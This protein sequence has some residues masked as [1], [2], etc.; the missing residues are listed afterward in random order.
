MQALAEACEVAT[1]GALEEGKGKN[2]LDP[3]Y[4]KALKLEPTAFGSNLNLVRL[5]HTSPWSLLY[6]LGVLQSTLIYMQAELGILEDIKKLLAPEAGDLTAQLYKLNVYAAPTASV[7]VL[8]QPQLGSD[9]LRE[10]IIEHACLNLH[11]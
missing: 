3:S 10:P 4:R 5:F 9:L 6:C 11:A 8:A 7:C 2:V 1:F